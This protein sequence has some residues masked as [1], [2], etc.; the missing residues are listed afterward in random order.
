MFEK[1]TFLKQKA[2]LSTKNIAYQSGLFHAPIKSTNKEY[3]DLCERLEIVDRILTK[4]GLEFEFASDYLEQIRQT[5]IRHSG[6]PNF[7]MKPKAVER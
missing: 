4:S 7:E 2:S 5:G 6:K 3:R 1:P